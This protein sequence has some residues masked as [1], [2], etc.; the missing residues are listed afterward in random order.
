MAIKDKIIN[1]L[2]RALKAEYIRLE[3]D[4]GI[5]GYVVS[6]QFEGMSTL[7]RQR[8][9][10][11]ALDNASDTLSPDERNRILMIA[12]LT[13]LEY[14]SVGAR[15]RIHKIR[16]IAD[17]AFEILLHG[18]LSDAEYVR[19]A[20]NNQKGVE[21]TE[22]KSSPE[23]IGTL[24]SFVA[25]ATQAEPLTKERAIHVLKSDRYIEVMPNA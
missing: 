16:E 25:K 9:I 8:L 1:A 22:P 3:D 19:G 12:G 17:G 20:L 10:D 21:T 7:D 6:R 13:P 2:F 14:Q 15:I 11:S 18:G 4:D 5:S 24:T 23:A